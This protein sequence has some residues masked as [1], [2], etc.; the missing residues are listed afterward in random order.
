MT[1][2]W[3]TEKNSSNLKKHGVSFEEAVRVFLD[4]NLL[5]IADPDESEE[6]WDVIG[7]A[8]K[9]LYV[10]Y[11]ERGEDNYRIIS[12]RKATKR[13]IDGYKNHDYGRY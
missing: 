7:F 11:T 12:A 4:P 5:V 1:F 3:D 9:V 2:E 6:R 13:E 8:G 10:V